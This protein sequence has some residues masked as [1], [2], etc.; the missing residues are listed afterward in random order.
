MWVRE[1]ERQQM[2]HSAQC[3]KI[4]NFKC[5]LF[6]RHYLCSHSLHCTHNLHF[7]DHE[8]QMK[9]ITYIFRA[10]IISLSFAWLFPHSHYRTQIVG[11]LYISEIDT[12]HNTHTH[13]QK[14]RKGRASVWCSYLYSFEW[15]F[16]SVC[17]SIFV[18]FMYVAQ[19]M[20]FAILPGGL[21]HFVWSI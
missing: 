3:H 1:R 21:V 12:V 16:W 9:C 19:N 11:A 4:I 20:C 14:R 8:R 10:K 7:T 15:F 5:A 6:S 2:A 13:T 17:R 18:T